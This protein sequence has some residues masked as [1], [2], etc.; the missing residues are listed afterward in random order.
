MDGT[1]FRHP[2]PANFNIYQRQVWV[3]GMIGETSRRVKVF[4][5]ETRDN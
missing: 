2:L 3:F 5:V 1:W 4:I